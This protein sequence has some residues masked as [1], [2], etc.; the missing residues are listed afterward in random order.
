MKK[1][2]LLV[3]YIMIVTPLTHA[4]NALCENC[5][6]YTL[7]LVDNKLYGS[8]PQFAGYDVSM[9]LPLDF[10]DDSLS[11]D[12]LLKTIRNQDT[13]GEFIFPNGNKSE[14]KYSLIP[15]HDST[16]VFMKTSNGWYPW[17][18][19]RIENKKV[20][21]S[22]DYWYCP[23]ATKADLEILDICFSNLKDSTSWHQ[24]D[25][26]KCDDDTSGKV[27]SLFCAIKVAS[28]EKYGEYNHRGT[29]MQKT[30]FVVDELRP[31]HAYAHAL[32]DFNNDSKT[33]FND[34]VNVLSIV[35]N[36]I[37]EELKTEEQR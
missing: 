1:I 26:R 13:R 14:I 19:L 23:P 24:A 21:F 7:E 5:I 36:R 16:T 9:T 6:E 28:I 34:I 25:D 31:N 35:R 3:G 12:Y 29:V 4:Q 32:M 17:D 20:I 11:I 2:F 30:R 8:S 15:Y 10:S 27:W 18:E 22:Y 33:T 37:E